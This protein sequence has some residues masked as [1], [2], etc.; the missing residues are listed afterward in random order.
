VAS[1]RASTFRNGGEL[2]AL[3]SELRASLATDPAQAESP[4]ADRDGAIP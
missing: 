2:L 1:G 3:L 4:V